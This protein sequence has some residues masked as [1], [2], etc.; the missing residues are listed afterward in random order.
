MEGVTESYSTKM[1]VILNQVLFLSIPQTQFHIQPHKHTILN[2]YRQYINLPF[3]YSLPPTR[4]T[5]VHQYTRYTCK[6]HLRNIIF[7]LA[8]RKGNFVHN[9]VKCPLNYCGLFI[10]A[11]YSI[12]VPQQIWPDSDYSRW[13]SHPIHTIFNLYTIIVNFPRNLSQTNKMEP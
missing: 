4:L 10:S 7:T 13:I 6:S 3:I 5:H 12:S 2:A 1:W 11:V 9:Y 8:T